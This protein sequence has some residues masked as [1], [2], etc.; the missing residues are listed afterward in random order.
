M[1][2]ASA[3]AWILFAVI[4]SL[5]GFNFWLSRRWVRDEAA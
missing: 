5:T 2:L 1:G 4:G 3:M